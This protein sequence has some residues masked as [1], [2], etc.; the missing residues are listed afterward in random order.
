MPTSSFS[1]GCEESSQD[2]INRPGRSRRWSGRASVGRLGSPRGSAAV[3]LI[4][5]LLLVIPSTRPANADIV[6]GTVSTDL[7]SAMGMTFVRWDTTTDPTNTFRTEGY[8]LM[9]NGGVG[10]ISFIEFNTPTIVSIRGVRLFAQNDGAI[11]GFRRAMSRFRLLADM[12]GDGALYETVVVDTTINIDY[13]Q[14][15]GNAATDPTNLDL[16]LPAAGPVTCQYWRLEVTQGTNVQPDDG[17]RLVEVD[18]LAAGTTTRVSVRTGGVQSDGQS[19]SAS[20]SADGR[21][22]AFTSWASNLVDDDTNGRWDVFV[23]DRLTGTTERVSLSSAR[24]QANGDSP[25]AV[26]SADGRFVAFISS[27]SNLVAD[28]T[29]GVRDVFVRDR[30]MAS[31]ERISVS[32]DEMQGDGEAPLQYESLA[33]SGDG[34]FVTFISS[35]TNLVTGDTNGLRDVFVRDCQAGTTERVSVSSAGLEGNGNSEPEGLAITPDGRYV[36]FASNANNLV[37]G[38]TNV[39]MDTFVHD[40]EM[41]TTERVSLNSQQVQG[42]S[43]S[44]YPAISADGRF[45]AFASW[46]GN[47]VAGDSNG[48]IDVFVRDREERT[49]SRVSVSSSGAQSDGQNWLVAMSADGLSVAFASF[50][51]NLVAGDTNEL[52]DFFLHDRQTRVTERITVS[53]AGVQSNNPDS[54]SAVPSISADGRFVA[55]VSGASNLV[56]EDTNGTLDIFVR[57]RRPQVEPSVAD[58]AVEASASP[59]TVPPGGQVTYLV[60]LVNRGPDTA[61]VDTVVLVTPAGAITGSADTVFIGST[62]ADGSV[63]ASITGVS[64]APAIPGPELTCQFFAGA[65]PALIVPGRHTFRLVANVSAAAVSGPLTSTI[66]VTSSVTE[67]GPGD[68]SVAATV[69]VIVPPP[70]PTPPN[71]QITR[72]AA[73]LTTLASAVTLR[74]SAS[75]NAGVHRVGWVNDR[76]SAGT[77][78][79]S[80]FGNPSWIARKIPLA[81]GT[82]TFTVTAYDNEGTPSAPAQID[83]VRIPE[84]EAVTN[85]LIDGVTVVT[86]GQLLV[87]EPSLA[88]GAIQFETDARLPVTTLHILL[89]GEALASSRGD[90]NVF[91]AAVDLS[92]LPRNLAP[93]PAHQLSAVVELSDGT[94]VV[95][96]VARGT[97]TLRSIPVR[98][99]SPVEPVAAPNENIQSRWTILP[100]LTS[101]PLQDL[102]VDSAGGVWAVAGS[103]IVLTTTDTT[104]VVGSEI[105]YVTELAGSSP[106]NALW[107]WDGA[108]WH[109]VSAADL[110]LSEPVLFTAIAVDATAL[111][112]GTNRGLVEAQLS[113]AIPRE[114]V[115]ASLRTAADGL[116][117]SWVSSI[118]AAAGRLLVAHRGSHFYRLHASAVKRYW[119]DGGGVSVRS[120]TAWTAYPSVRRDDGNWEGVAGFD[121]VAVAAVGPAG[122]WAASEVGL[123]VFDGSFSYHSPST[124]LPLDSVIA[125][126]ASDSGEL[127]AAGGSGVALLQNGSWTTFPDGPNGP[128]S[129]NVRDVRIDGTGEVFFATSSG[130]ASVDPTTHVWTRHQE[131]E[132]G[133]LAV[134]QRGRVHT[135]IDSAGQQTVAGF[136]SALAVALDSPADG[137]RF[138][139]DTSTGLATVTLGWNPVPMAQGYEVFLSG[140]LLGRTTSTSRAVALRAGDYTWTVRAL[141]SG[142]MAGSR[143]APRSLRVGESRD[144]S[145]AEFLLI[146]R[147]A[148]GVP[149]V[150]D[151]FREPAT[152]SWQTFIVDPRFDATAPASEMDLAATADG[153]LASSTSAGLPALE[154]YP[155]PLSPSVA[156]AW[157]Q[158]RRVSVTSEPSGYVTYVSSTEIKLYDRIFGESA[159][160][161]AAANLWDV[162]GLSDGR[163]AVLDAGT[164]VRIFERREAG[165]SITPVRDIAVGDPLLALDIAPLPDGGFVVLVLDTAINEPRYAIA[166]YDTGLSRRSLIRLDD[167]A[168]ALAPALDVAADEEGRIFVLFPG[169]A[170]YMTRDV[171]ESPTW[172][173]VPVSLPS[174]GSDATAIATYVTPA[175]RAA[176]VSTPDVPPPDAPPASATVMRLGSDWF[177]YTPDGFTGCQTAGPAWILGFLR[178]DGPITCDSVAAPTRL[179]GTGLYLDYNPQAYGSMPAGAQAL[180]L[181]EGPFTLNLQDGRID[182]TGPLVL[183]LPGVGTL[184]AGRLGILGMGEYRESTQRK[185]IGIAAGRTDG[186]FG[187]AGKNLEFAQLLLTDVGGTFHQTFG[188][189]DGVLAP[190]DEGSIGFTDVPLRLRTTGD[191]TTTTTAPACALRF[192][193]VR[194]E[195]LSSVGAARFDLDLAGLCIN[196]DA[197]T[198]E[199]S[200]TPFGFVLAVTLNAG[201]ITESGVEAASAALEIIGLKTFEITGVRAGAQGFH[202]DSAPGLTLAGIGTVM[203]DVTL[204]L[205]GPDRPGSFSAGSAELGF[206]NVTGH[207]DQLKVPFNFFSVPP[208]SYPTAGGGG[209]LIGTESFPLFKVDMAPGLEIGSDSITIPALE[210]EVRRKPEN[211]ESWFSASFAGGRITRDSVMLF[212]AP[213]VNI[214]G[215]SFDFEQVELGANGFFTSQVDVRAPVGP[216]ITLRGFSISP[217]GTIGITGGGFRKAGLAFDL[218]TRAPCPDGFCFTAS[219]SLAPIIKNARGD[220]D[221]MG[222]S[223]NLRRFTFDAITLGPLRVKDP[224]FDFGSDD[225]ISI[226][227]TVGFGRFPDVTG[228]IV[229]ENGALKDLSLSAVFPV[230]GYPLYGPLFLQSVSGHLALAGTE[231]EMNANVLLS[232]GPKLKFAPFVPEPLYLVTLEG[233]VTVSGLGYFQTNAQIRLLG[234]PMAQSMAIVGNVYLGEPKQFVG[235]GMYFEGSILLFG[236]VL[237]VDMRAWVYPPL[238]GLLAPGPQQGTY[239]GDLRGTLQIPPYVP[240]IGG[241]TFGQAGVALRGTFGSATEPAKAAFSGSVSIPLCTPPIYYC[242]GIQWCRKCWRTFLGRIC[243]PPYP[244]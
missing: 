65:D 210:L 46:A 241:L 224:L 194:A 119:L 164:T 14:Q 41:D 49:T 197:V 198:F 217:A 136:E 160:V 221:I 6:P 168:A 230:P 121:V 128:P 140:A 150:V 196:P 157:V 73:T 87:E 145:D 30:Q 232:G 233:A 105:R 54:A 107:H 227:A 111:W 64:C 242:T 130:V 201:S 4:S 216:Q 148:D 120:G 166:T 214:F 235:V 82:N 11:N 151:V 33:I 61:P 104:E 28:D 231:T 200:S 125:L 79:G 205:P 59:D 114:I 98:I 170:V 137:A 207:L 243:T 179:S 118:R 76:G 18:A 23:H 57:D 202:F 66:R 83:V 43:S 108:S 48:T 236:G 228:G 212:D 78:T 93:A 208:G 146:H 21:F 53:T 52:F 238:G 172:T 20:M 133:A 96:P 67:Q 147:T 223:V 218:A 25:R 81:D 88:T 12:D 209:L 70:P 185:G 181:F 132:A 15:A 85:L 63:N 91:S 143:S 89:N 50:G 16:T 175:P 139:T 47:L 45:V 162:A 204:L 180:P 22:V 163:V 149:R 80:S 40:R 34:R 117:G 195:V 42:D 97:Q 110:G 173:L 109:P 86:G 153:R 159:A 72:P 101:G 156:P 171:G 189:I 169:G 183:K 152:T 115:S 7:F 234:F 193:Q 10:S 44:S 237:D 219:F 37:A 190:F 39:R 3:S 167:S 188:G 2:Q 31:T 36:A 220:V 178:S 113:E 244:C 19:Q 191:L 215:A 199:P 95:L 165:G 13:S 129:S 116:A 29:N 112:I 99:N 186:A 138:A 102:A 127:W 174:G 84:A 144:R 213:P 135:A 203:S 1:A 74:G 92:R 24:A 155:D 177:V 184:A 8:T 69:Q 77:A 154:Q 17:V 131:G 106:D 192:P 222:G 239:G 182:V 26:I 123:S 229:L 124:G 141:L 51:R 27:A 68:E 9:R 206:N 103:P 5:L 226:G 158:P 187:S 60:T 38:D 122:F 240:I 225:I 62:H 126:D 56:E 211:P 58:L 94:S 35:A 134:D 161:T 176:R 142:N 32:S 100:A 90:G 71:V 55:F 75:D